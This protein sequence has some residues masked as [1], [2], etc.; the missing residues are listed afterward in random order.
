MRIELTNEQVGIIKTMKSAVAIL[1]KSNKPV[2]GLVRQL[3]TI[4]AILDSVEDNILT[5]D[6]DKLKAV[7]DALGLL[8]ELT[9]NRVYEDSA[10]FRLYA[11]LRGLLNN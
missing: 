8:L 4:H 6:N 5:I 2:S 11:E 10:T 1:N 9:G 3:L 7:V